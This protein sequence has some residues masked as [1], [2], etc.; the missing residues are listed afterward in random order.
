MGRST[1]RARRSS[2]A[3]LLHWLGLDPA[4]VDAGL[5]APVR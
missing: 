2:A 1:A 3:T 4:R 5:A